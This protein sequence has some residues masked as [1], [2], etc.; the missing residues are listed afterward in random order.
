MFATA[1]RIEAPAPAEIGTVILDQDRFGGVVK[2]LGAGTGDGSGLGKFRIKPLGIRLHLDL[3][4]A[5]DRV[6]I[7]AATGNDG[8]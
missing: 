3:V 7:W 5:V 1:I 6:H 8:E 4:E 2:E